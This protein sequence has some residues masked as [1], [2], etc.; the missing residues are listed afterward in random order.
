MNQLRPST[1]AE[2]LGQKEVK[3]VS[4]FVFRQILI[5]LHPF[6]PFITEKIWLIVNQHKKN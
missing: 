1:L 5:M 3:E 4:A 6:I 2:I